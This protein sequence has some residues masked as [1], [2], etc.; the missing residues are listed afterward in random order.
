MDLYSYSEKYVGK[1]P[2]T[3]YTLEQKVEKLWNAH[4]ELHQDKEVI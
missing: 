2:V 3:E 4:P 1:K